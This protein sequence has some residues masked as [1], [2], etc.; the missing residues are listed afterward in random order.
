AVQMAL[1][2]LNGGQERALVRN[3]YR[4]T[5]AFSDDVPLEDLRL[6]HAETLLDKEIL[7]HLG[8]GRSVVLTGNPGDG[9]T[10]LLRILADQMGRDVVVERDASAVSNDE[11]YDHW[12]DACDRGV[13]YALAINEAVLFR[14]AAAYPDF[15]P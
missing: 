5:T 15:Q 9:K 11:V 10:H 2:D 13:P 8:E 3:L 4:G 7:T 6:L 14:L 12:K 1:S